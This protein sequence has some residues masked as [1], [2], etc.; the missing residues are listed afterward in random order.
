M[1]EFTRPK[2]AN[3]IIYTGFLW[4]G[5]IHTCQLYDRLYRIK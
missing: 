1:V 5:L 3:A 2:M 4:E